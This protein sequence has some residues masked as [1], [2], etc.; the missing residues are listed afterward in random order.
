MGEQIN[1]FQAWMP[2]QKSADGGFVGILS[3][4]SIDRDGEFMSKQ[5]LQSW[6][7][8]AR[9]LPMLAN[10]EN[11]LEKL[12]G[13]WTEKKLITKGENTAL[14]A[15]PFFL[16]SNPLGVQAKAM[17]DE[18]LSKGLGIG[19]SIGAIPKGEMVEKEIDGQKF[20]GFTEAEILEATIVPI[21]SNRNASFSAVAKSFG[22][23]KKKDEEEE[24]KKPKAPTYK[25]YEADGAHTHP[26]IEAKVDE[27]R[28]MVKGFDLE[29][30]K[31]AKLDRCV[32]QLMEDHNFK[33]Q[34][35]R[36]KEESAF[37]VCQARLGKKS[38]EKMEET[39]KM[40][41]E[42]KKEEAPVEEAAPV[43]EEAAPEVEAAPVEEAEAAPEPEA[44]E[45][46]APAAEEEAPVV[47]ESA[48]LKEASAKIAALEKEIK[49]LKERPILKGTVEGPLVEKEVEQDLSFAG[50][51]KAKYGGQ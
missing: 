9:P 42:I 15:K 23:K 19:I 7:K 34:E 3:D 27:L 4:D 45:E 18:A 2:L 8:D 51:L 10:H 39:T 31:G 20:K 36:T 49:D 28:Q 22:F 38:F 5:L 21:Q 11:K 32:R 16:E 12:I 41:E 14:V 13:G 26:E 17:V 48:E 33:P 1:K 24:K 50:L 6:V 35:G 43:A 46:A 30:E 47:E 40:V 25:A 44:V 37:A 29:V